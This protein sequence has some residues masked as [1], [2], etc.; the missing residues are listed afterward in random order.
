MSQG[1][2]VRADAKMYGD[3]L[4][5]I[6]YNL[7]TVRRKNNIDRRR[8]PLSAPRRYPRAPWI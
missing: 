6:D 5:L 8:G 4:R 2:S 1:M 7:A 3:I